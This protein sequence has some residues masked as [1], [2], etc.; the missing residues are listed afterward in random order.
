MPFDSYVI[1]GLVFA[2][3]AFK[4]LKLRSGLGRLAV[5]IFPV[6]NSCPIPRKAGFAS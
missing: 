4:R 2:Q 6:P 5:P 3:K 1:N